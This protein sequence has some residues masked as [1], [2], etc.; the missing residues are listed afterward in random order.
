[1]PSSSV[2]V[3]LSLCVASL[4]GCYQ[5]STNPSP[6]RTVET[7]LRLLHDRDALVRRTA[8]ESLG[9]IGDPQAV[10]GLVVALGD[11]SPIVREASVRSLGDIG[12]LQMNTRNQIADLLVDSVP[13]VRA[14][15][16][17]TLAAL[18]SSKERWPLAMSQLAHGNPEIRRA[19]I[20]A[21]ESTDSPE[22]L[23]ALRD[24]LHDPEPQVRRAAVAVLGQSGDTKV[25]E[26]FRL[27]LR[28]ESSADVRAEIAHQ[29]QF[30]PEGE[31]K[32]GLR[33]LITHDESAQVRRWAD[34]TLRGL[35]GV[36]DS[37]SRPQPTPP[38]VPV[39]SHRYP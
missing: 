24:K 9:K 13:S 32:E 22:V 16:S 29:L 23:M 1:M 39:P 5:P 17:Q 6:Q 2:S 7:L 8:A 38:A 37:D 18:D 27:H 26:L 30:F 4:L 25:V 36:R 21:L 31:S 14:A 10:P 34:H 15:A 12:P 20:Q 19:V 35:R 11:Q 28:A 3:L 33:Y